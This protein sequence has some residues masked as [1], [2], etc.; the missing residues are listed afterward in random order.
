MVYVEKM[1]RPTEPLPFV[2]FVILMALMVSLVAMSTDIMLPALKI[3]GSDLYVVDISDTQRIVIALFFGFGVGQILAGPLSDAYGRKPIVYLGFCIFIVGCILSMLA[4][5]FNA[6]LAGRA[7]QGFGAAGPR[8]I[9]IAMVRDGYS[10]RVMA[11]IM[12]FIMTVFI[13]VPALAPFIGQGILMFTGWR[14]LFA[15]LLIK[16]SVAFFWF[17]LRQPETLLPEKRKAFGLASLV[18]GILEILS[19]RY[20]VGYTVAS[21]MVFGALVAYLATARQIFQDIF[22]VGE[23]FPVYFGAA[24][25]AI[26]IGYLLNSKLVIQLGMRRLA[27]RGLMVA[28]AVSTLLSALLIIFPGTPPIWVFLGWLL[29]E[30]CCMGF[31]FGNLNTLAIEPL[32]HIAGLGAAMIG[33]I[34][35]LIAL[36]L[37]VF[38]GAHFDGTVLPLVSGFAVLNFAALGLIAWINMIKIN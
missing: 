18:A 29:V 10:G 12:S 13:L 30:F 33:S 35:T 32:G 38:I 21:G 25:I 8:V 6:M 16:A 4:N 26:G 7:L 5:E 24:A 34:S 27:M 11:R 28:S 37:S 9:S 23:L 3:I 19:S 15:L 17:A 22:F 36:P 31:V 14:G 20:V 2:E 1:N